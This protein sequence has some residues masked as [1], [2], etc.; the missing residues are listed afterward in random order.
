MRFVAADF[1]DDPLQRV[2]FSDVMRSC[3]RTSVV[4]DVRIYVHIGCV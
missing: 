2:V 1:A 3:I 4:R